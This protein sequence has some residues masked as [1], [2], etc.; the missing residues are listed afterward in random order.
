MAFA[1]ETA[2]AAPPGAASGTLIAT[3]YIERWLA[4]DD[5]K[6]PEITTSEVRDELCA[7]GRKTAWA[8]ETA[9]GMYEVHV[10]SAF[11]LSLGGHA[12][13]AAP[14]F[15]V[16]GDRASSHVWKNLNDPVVAF[17]QFRSAAMAAES[18]AR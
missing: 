17:G 7:A 16:L 2:D 14:H 12:R 6:T 5:V 4:E 3:M 18:G 13:E 1:R 15:R 10:H 8:P 11:A 9:L